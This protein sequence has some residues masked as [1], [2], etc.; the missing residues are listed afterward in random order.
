VL[1]DRGEHDEARK[2]LNEVRRIDPKNASLE[3][4]ER[5]LKP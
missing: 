5:K 2:V 1:W 3:R 4:T